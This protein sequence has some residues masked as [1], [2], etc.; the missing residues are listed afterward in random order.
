MEA[1]ILAGGYGRRLHPLT[2]SMPKCMIPINGRPMMDYNL[3]LL[4]RYGIRKVVVSCGHKWKKIKDHYG[5]KLIYSVEEGPLG[6]GG[7][8]AKAINFLEGE[9]FIFLNCDD[10]T[11]IDLNRLMRLGSNSIVLARFNSPFGIVT[12]KGRKVLKFEQKPLLN[13]WAWCGVAMLNK[14]LPFPKKG[15]LETELFPNIELKAYKHLGLWKTVN[16]MKDLEEVERMI[17]SNR[18]MLGSPK[19]YQV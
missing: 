10:L 13:H 8:I 16:T 15:S 7:A 12:V 17:K 14:N 6:T 19:F 1:I 2:A 18:F 9:D 5:N 11:D 4:R 3:A